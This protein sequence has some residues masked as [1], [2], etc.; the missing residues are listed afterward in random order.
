MVAQVYVIGV[1]S[2]IIIVISA[3]FIGFVLALQ[4]Y[5]TLT[6]FSAVSGLGPLVALSVLR[7]LG[8]VIT[9][10]LVA[11]R[12]GSALTSEIGLMKATEQL[13]SLTMMGINPVRF[14]L[15]PRLWGGLIAMPMLNALFCAISIYAGYLI[16][17]KA[18]GVYEGTFWSNMQQNVSFSTDV[19][20]GLIKSFVFGIVVTWIALYQGYEAKTNSEG[21]ARATTK[22]VVYASCSILFLDFIMTS[23]ML[24]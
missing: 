11:G 16:S 12:A 4:G 13:S 8:P 9:G 20:N 18:L 17:V 21:I 10:L 7:E 6:K 14:I 15:A 24:N 19:M 2:F 23:L 1:Q 5:Y 3:F 22:T